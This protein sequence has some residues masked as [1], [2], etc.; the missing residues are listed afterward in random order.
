MEGGD[1][2]GLSVMDD[3]AVESWGR[4]LILSVLA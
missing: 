3:Y 2:K 1:G 4:G